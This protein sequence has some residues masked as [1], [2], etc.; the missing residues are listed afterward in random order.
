M[1]VTMVKAFH[2][3][4]KEFGL[5]EKILSFN[6]DNVSSND[7]Q[8]TKMDQLD[9]SFDKENRAR[10]F[11]HTLQLLAKT[12]LKPFNSALSGKATEDDEMPITE[13]IEDPDGLLMPEDEDKDKDRVTDHDDEEDKDDGIDKLAELSEDEQTRLLEDTTAVCQAVTK[14]RINNGVEIFLVLTNFISR[15]DNSRLQSF[16]Q[17]LSLFRLGVAIAVT[18]SSKSA[19]SPMMS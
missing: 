10:C 13:E 3:M 8:M 16:I 15:S 4:L 7:M 12:L 1:G 9:N 5:T 17:Q 18:S 11:N 2:N 19:P 6:A 14:V